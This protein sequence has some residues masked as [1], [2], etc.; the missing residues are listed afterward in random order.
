MLSLRCSLSVAFSI[1]FLGGFFRGRKECRVCVL[2][3]EDIRYMSFFPNTK[4]TMQSLSR[5]ERSENR[6]IISQKSLSF[7]SLLFAPQKAFVF[8]TL[9]KDLTTKREIWSQTVSDHHIL[10]KVI[11]TELGIHSSAEQP[12]HPMHRLPTFGVLVQCYQF[13]YHLRLFL[14]T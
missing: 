4:Q 13:E 6:F 2:I 8:V 3:N 7:R 10:F 14:H 5:D 1:L 11:H 12:W 9:I